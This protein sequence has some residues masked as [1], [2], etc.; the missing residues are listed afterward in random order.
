MK[1]V[2]LG[3]STEKAGDRGPWRGLF[4]R[5]TQQQKE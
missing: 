5:V 1:L 4:D 2:E 3:E